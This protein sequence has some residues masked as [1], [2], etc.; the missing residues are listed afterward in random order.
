MK[1]T[2]MLFRFAA[3][4]ASAVFS[5]SCCNDGVKPVKNVILMI[6]DGNS[7]SLLSVVRWYREYTDPQNG[8]AS[9]AIDPYLCGM[10]REQC[11]DSPVPESS[12]AISAYMTGQFVQGPNICIYP[13]AH[14]GQ[15]I[16]SINPDSTWQPLATVMEGA[17]ILKD[18][19]LG[20]VVTVKA[21]HATPAG[22]TAH[23][24]SRNDNRTIIRQIASNR[25][26]VVFG[27]GLR[28]LDDEVK[29]ILADNSIDVI[30]KDM[31]AF[32]AY[33]GEKVWAL[34]TKGDMAYDCDRD[35]TAEPSLEEMT[36]KALKLLSKK[37]NGFFLMVEGS[38]IDYAAHGNDVGGLISEFDAFDKAVAA[39]LDFARKDGN[40]TVIVVPDHGTSGVSM[41]DRRYTEYVKKG[42]DS[43]FVNV[44]GLN[45]SAAVM[46]TRLREC[47]IADIP[48]VFKECTGMDLTPA[49][50]SCLVNA[51]DDVE[52][53]YMN[54]NYS[55]NLQAE[56]NRIIASHTHIGYVSGGHTAEDLFLAVYNPNGQCPTG[57]LRATELTDYMAAVAGLPISLKELTSR[58][59]VRHDVLLEGRDYV[60]EGKDDKAVLNIGEGRL[61]VPANRSYV[62]RDGEKLP[63]A[64]V[65]VYIKETGNFF[66]SKEILD[67]L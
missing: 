31:D 48:H 11:S 50:L 42:L 62:I 38:K 16:V 6:P 63:L 52:T 53:N 24:V 14:P 7:T 35:T 21:S 57:L 10:V 55:Y 66:I 9:L 58:I 44:S 20:L 30:E 17:K 32:R 13:A 29:E 28:Y 54:I 33:D 1:G 61:L 22:T 39:A 64:S 23:S 34:F 8:N 15:D 25:V 56:I 5:L 59:F 47:A 4:A 45:V 65:S 49:E 41:G 26:D 37:R 18:K 19:A 46:E 60:V 67:Y 40:T 3:V 12:A 36:R 2:G 43:I 51:K 27:G